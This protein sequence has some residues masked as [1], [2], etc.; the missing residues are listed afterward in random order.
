MS[1]L[2]GV[3]RMSY[4]CFMYDGHPSYGP[5]DHVFY[6]ALLCSGTGLSG[7]VKEAENSSELSSRTR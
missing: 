7:Y 1:F 6:L 3:E 4:D 2:E 5:M